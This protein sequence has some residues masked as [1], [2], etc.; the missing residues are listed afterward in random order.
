[1][2]GY[3]DRNLG[4]AQVLSSVT[5]PTKKSQNTNLKNRDLKLFSINLQHSY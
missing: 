2:Y 4:T 1:M 5:L 3:F